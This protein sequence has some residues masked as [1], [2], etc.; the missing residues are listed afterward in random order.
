MNAYLYGKRNNKYRIIFTIRGADV[1][2]L[3]IHHGVRGELR[4]DED[5][6]D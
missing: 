2:I 1:V 5:P 4:P 3:S 6:A